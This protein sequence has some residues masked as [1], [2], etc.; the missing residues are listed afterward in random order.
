VTPLFR[1]CAHKQRN[2][3]H[4]ERSLAIAVW[5]ALSTSV[6]VGKFI[7]FIASVGIR[8]NLVQRVFFVYD[9]L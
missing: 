9:S 4:P 8:L 1:N 7:E 5:L 6:A 2:R 3:V